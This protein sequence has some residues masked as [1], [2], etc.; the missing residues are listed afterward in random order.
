LLERAQRIAL[1]DRVNE[2]IV[3]LASLFLLKLQFFV[4]ASHGA[5]SSSMIT[6]GFGVLA[7]SRSRHLET[8]IESHHLGSG[9]SLVLFLL[10]F[11]LL[12]DR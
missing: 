11:K 10:L 9:L 3:R 6:R 12:K 7:S 2:S 5:H 4:L 1:I 8:L